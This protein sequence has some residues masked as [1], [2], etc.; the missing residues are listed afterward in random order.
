MKNYKTFSFS[1]H[2]INKIKQ[3]FEPF[4]SM[5]VILFKYLALVFNI[6]LLLFQ[7]N[8]LGNQAFL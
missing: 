2:L 4:Q 8:A 7:Y 1:I 3:N 6:F 5:N